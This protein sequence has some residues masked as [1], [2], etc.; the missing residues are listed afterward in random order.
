MMTPAEFLA[1]VEAFLASEGISASA[2]G[3]QTLRDPSFV[4]DLRKG[5][6]VSLDIAC[7]IQAFMDAHIIAK[8]ERATESDTE[9]A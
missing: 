6:A 7:Q 5:R 2:F 1:R 9:A 3:V 4:F 8:H